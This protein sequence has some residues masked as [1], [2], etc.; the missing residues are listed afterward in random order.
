MD[1]YVGGAIFSKTQHCPSL[2]ERSYA[3]SNE[4]KQIHPLN[5]NPKLSCTL[6]SDFIL[7]DVVI[8]L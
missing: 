7:S 4:R 1:H 5:L 2:I 8:M 6:F 3:M